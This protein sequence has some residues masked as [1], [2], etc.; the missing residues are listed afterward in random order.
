MKK[1]VRIDADNIG[2]RIELALLKGDTDTAQRIH[3]VVQ[4]AMEGIKQKIMATPLWRIL[5]TGCD[6]ALFEAVD[7]NDLLKNL[8]ALRLEFFTLTQYSLSIGVGNSIQEAVFNLRIA[9]LMG[10]DRVVGF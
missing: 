3:H 2:D 4:L 10:K 5:M 1:I 9:K 7:D 6:D 8:E